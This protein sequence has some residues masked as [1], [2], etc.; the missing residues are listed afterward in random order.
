MKKLLLLAAAV[1]AVCAL[2]CVVVYAIN[3]RKPPEEWVGQRLGLR[4]EALEE[5]R[6]AHGRYA[7]TCAEMCVRIQASD[8][9]LARLIA[10]SREV[11]PEITAAIAQSDALRNECRQNMLAH[12]YAVAAMLEADQARSYLQMVLPLIVEPELMSQQHQHP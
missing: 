8:Q 4:G 6:Q 11:T 2:T 10:S 12:F 1:F 5:F 3:M 9:E 7:A